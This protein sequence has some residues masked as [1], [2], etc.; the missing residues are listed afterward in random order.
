IVW[1]LTGLWHGANWNYV[2]WGIYF[3]ILIALERAFLSAFLE[4]LHVTFRHAYLVFAV[5][6][7][8]VLFV[9]EDVREMMRYLKAMFLPIGRQLY[10]TFFLYHVTSFAAV[11]VICIIAATPLGHVVWRKLPKQAKPVL[12]IFGI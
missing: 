2:I 6:V 7:S 4:K 1:A 9:H 10:D 3:G 8:W 11:L 12:N 5:L